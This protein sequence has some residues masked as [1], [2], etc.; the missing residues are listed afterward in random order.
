MGG[1][2][3]GHVGSHVGSHMGGLYRCIGGEERRGG[4]RGALLCSK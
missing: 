3:G 4:A 1:H 2:V